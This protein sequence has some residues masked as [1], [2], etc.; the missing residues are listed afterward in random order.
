[1][2]QFGQTLLKEGAAPPPPQPP[3]KHWTA[4]DLATAD[5]PE[6]ETF[7]GSI[8]AR[9]TILLLAGRRGSGKTHVVIHLAGCLVFGSGA[10]F[11]LRV[12]GPLRVLLLSQEMSEVPIRARILK[13]F[14]TSQLREL[15]DRLTII[16]KDRSVSLASDEGAD[17]IVGLATQH[18]AD[19]VIIDA[20]RDVKGAVKENDNDEMGIVMLRLRDRVAE[21]AKVAVVLL[22]HFGKIHKDE[23]ESGRG[24]SV[25][26][27]VAAD[28]IYIRDPKDGS[29][30]RSGTFSK[31]RDGSHQDQEFE[32][33]IY[34]EPETNTIQVA[35]TLQAGTNEDLD[36]KAAVAQ[37]KKVGGLGSSATEIRS[38]LSWEKRAGNR[39]LGRAVELGMLERFNARSAGLSRSVNELAYRIPAVSVQESIL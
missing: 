1:M 7:L 6:P 25:I 26:E 21:K 19:V 37:V 14:T 39:R 10:P 2:G 22:H 12:S 5:I 17:Y 13:H 32:F 36:I 28:I 27:D 23:T 33:E 20:L 3:P 15:G 4:L 30:K 16:C 35:F 18:A 38:A 24:A 34:D 29:G 9:Q 8:L 11:G 31:T